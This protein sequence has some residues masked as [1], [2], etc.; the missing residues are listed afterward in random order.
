[1]TDDE[2]ESKVAAMNAWLDEQDCEEAGT[3]RFLL[4]SLHVD[5]DVLA[6]LLDPSATVPLPS[7]YPIDEV[8]KQIAADIVKAEANAPPDLPAQFLENRRL[9]ARQRALAS[10]REA[11]KIA[12]EWR[13]HCREQGLDPD[14]AKPL[15]GN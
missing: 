13:E 1:M 2:A 7:N 9:A 14:T 11:E 15:S 8:D 12:D 4:G 5:A 10:F 3:L 6:A